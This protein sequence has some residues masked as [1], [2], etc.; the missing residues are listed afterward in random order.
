VGLVGEGLSNEEIA[1]RLVV[2]PA[3]A[4]THV[5]ATPPVGSRPWPRV[6][7]PRAH[8]DP[9]LASALCVLRSPLW[10][11]SCPGTC[12]NALSRDMCQSG[13]V[14]GISAA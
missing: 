1:E 6:T 9:A 4:R 5:P 8:A 7:T 14:V 2:S 12:V 3:T 11:L 13:G 10:G